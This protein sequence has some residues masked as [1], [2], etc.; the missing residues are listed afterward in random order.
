[1][2]NEEDQ[3][4]FFSSLKVASIAELKLPPLIFIDLRLFDIRKIIYLQARC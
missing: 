3:A 4:T 1:V 2:I